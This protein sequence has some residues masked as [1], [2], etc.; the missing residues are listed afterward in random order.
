MQN[1]I[2]DEGLSEEKG[3]NELTSGVL[4]ALGN[5]I[6][7]EINQNKGHLDLGTYGLV[8]TG[9]IS[10][11]YQEK[12]GPKVNSFWEQLD[13]LVSI[14]RSNATGSAQYIHSPKA[15]GTYNYGATKRIELFVSPEDMQELADKVIEYKDEVTGIDVYFKLY[16]LFHS[17]LLH[18]LRHA[19]D[20]MRTDGMIF[21]NKKTI[22]FQ[23][24]YGHMNTEP[25]SDEDPEVFK[26]QRGKAYLQQPHEIWARASQAMHNLRYTVGT[27]EFDETVRMIPLKLVVTQFRT[28]FK[29]W[30]NISDK[31]KRRLVKAVANQWNEVDIDLKQKN[32]S[33]SVELAELRRYIRSVVAEVVS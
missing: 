32:A 21:K 17:L 20:D 13:L 24:K 6:A 11:K 23:D 30:N 2:I 1:Q 33:N 28:N 15:D 22:K 29:W 27:A 14:V 31:A 5:Q 25:A 10:Q 18:E 9:G 26:K 7:Q 16:Y 4:V 8:H 12:L 19:F 3:L